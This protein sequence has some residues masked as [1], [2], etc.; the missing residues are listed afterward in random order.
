MLNVK[1]LQFYRA[2]IGSQFAKQQEEMAKTPKVP[3]NIK[4]EI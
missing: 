2:Y 1:E 4:N 3:V